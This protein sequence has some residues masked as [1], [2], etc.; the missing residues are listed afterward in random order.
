MLR[1]FLILFCLLAVE[2][3]PAQVKFTTNMSDSRLGRLA[4]AK[5]A[6]TKLKRYKKMYHQDSLQAAKEHRK[7]MRDSLGTKGYK[8]HQDSLLR[9][10][11]FGFTKNTQLSRMQASRPGLA[12]PLD[13]L[14]G[15]ISDD[16]LRILKR[17]YNREHMPSDSLSGMEMMAK[18]GMYGTMMDTYGSRAGVPTDSASMANQMAVEEQ[19]KSF[20]P[21]ELRGGQ[22][23]G[24]SQMAGEENTTKAMAENL[25]PEQMQAATAA[26]AVLKKGYISVPNSNDLSSAKKRNSLEGSPL[27]QRIFLGGNVA[28]QS[29]N[30]AILDVDIQ[31]GYKFNRDFA[32]GIGFIIREQFDKQPSML[33]GDAYGHS[34]FA[35]HDLPFGIFAYAEFQNIK[36]QSLFQENLVEAEWQQSFMLGI[37]K[38]LPLTSFL[39]LTAMILYD[40]NYKNNDLHARPI[41]VRFGYRVSELAFRKK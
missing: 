38:E 19:L 35:T 6:R 34:V 23:F 16:S 30:P 12:H 29:I 24:G 33:V 13:T 14:K 27:K 40:F 11:K 20:L 41:V 36:T 22:E 4:R 28:L 32:M 39:N 21:E 10:K 15:R 2:V 18:Y 25:P 5:D 3:L 26:M 7:Q 37:G 31:V 17:E 1:I 8:A 9:V